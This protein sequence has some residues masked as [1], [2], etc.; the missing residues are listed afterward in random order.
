MAKIE[1]IKAR[2]E[3]MI[4]N[5]DRQSNRD[6]TPDGERNELATDLKDQK[7]FYDKQIEELKTLVLSNTYGEADRAYVSEIGQSV[8]HLIDQVN[9]LID[10]HDI[11]HAKI[12]VVDPA[13]PTKRKQEPT[14]SLP[15]LQTN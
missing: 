7:A 3:R 11:I 1:D 2:V 14:L 13:S 6:G 5:G 10:G 8:D 12:D 9:E 15:A 4:L